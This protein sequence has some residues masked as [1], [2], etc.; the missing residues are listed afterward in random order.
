MTYVP[1]VPAYP[2][3][4]VASTPWIARVRCSADTLNTA[5]NAKACRRHLLRPVGGAV[6]R[7]GSACIVIGVS[8]VVVSFVSVVRSVRTVRRRMSASANLARENV[9]VF[10][11]SL[12]RAAPLSFFEE[13]S[14]SEL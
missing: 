6:P 12:P 10:G 14:F 4:S 8:V 1:V 5:V 7:G 11:A 3:A 2:A 13:E 9:I